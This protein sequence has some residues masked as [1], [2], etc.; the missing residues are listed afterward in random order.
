MKFR[1]SLFFLASLITFSCLSAKA[2]IFNSKDINGWSKVGQSCGIQGSFYTKYQ[3][4]SDSTKY[5]VYYQSST[6]ND[7]WKVK[8]VSLNDANSKMN[9]KCSTDTYQPD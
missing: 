5:G 6:A 9:T 1:F 4:N 8:N 3:K 2:D 7:S